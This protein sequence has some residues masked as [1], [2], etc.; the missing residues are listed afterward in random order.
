MSTEPYREGRGFPAPSPELEDFYARWNAA[1]EEL[2]RLEG[3]R[4]YRDGDLACEYVTRYDQGLH[5]TKSSLYIFPAPGDKSQNESKTHKTLRMVRK[6][7]LSMVY[8]KFRW[9]IF[10]VVLMSFVFMAVATSEE[11]RNM[12]RDKNMYYHAELAFTSF[13]CF[14]FVLKLIAMGG[15]GDEKSY[16][17]DLTNIFDFFV[18]VIGCLSLTPAIDNYGAIRS[19]RLL[20]VFKAIN[21]VRIVRR[22]VHALIAAIPALKSVA[23]FTIYIV[24]LFSAFFLRI[25]MNRL[26]YRC[27]DEAT[28]TFYPDSFCSP[29]QTSGRKCPTGQVC[30][31]YGENPQNGV[32]SFDNL[33]NSMLT[34]L[35]CIS[36]EGWTEVMFITGDAVSKWLYGIFLVLMLL[37]AMLAIKLISA[38]VVMKYNDSYQSESNIQAEIDRRKAR[39][40]RHRFYR[41]ILDFRDKVRA[42]RPPLPPHPVGNGLNADR[43]NP[44]NE[45]ALDFLFERLKQG[46]ALPLCI[47]LNLYE[48]WHEKNVLDRCA[49]RFYAQAGILER[50]V[51]FLEY[52]FR[53]PVFIGSKSPFMS[54]TKEEMAAIERERDKDIGQRIKELQTD[55][56]EFVQLLESAVLPEDYEMPVNSNPG[57]VVDIQNLD[58]Q[59]LESFYKSAEAEI[60]EEFKYYFERVRFY[61][62]LIMKTRGAEVSFFAWI[63]GVSWRDNFRRWI[64]NSPTCIM[65][66][67]GIPGQSDESYLEDKFEVYIRTFIEQGDI[68]AET[69][70]AALTRSTSTRASLFKPKE[71]IRAWTWY[72]ALLTLTSFY[73]F[74]TLC[75]NHWG[76]SS[77]TSD[78]IEASSIICLIIYGIDLIIK[79]VISWPYFRYDALNVFEFFAT[80][81][82]LIEIIWRKGA[83]SLTILQIFRILRLRSTK[84]KGIARF[85]RIIVKSASGTLVCSIVVMTFVLVCAVISRSFLSGST[86]AENEFNG[87]F[88]A[89]LRSFQIITPEN[90]NSVLYAAKEYDG[91]RGVI[92]VTFIFFVGFYIVIAM[93]TAVLISS[94]TEEDEESEERRREANL[95]ALRERLAECHKKI[96]DLRFFIPPSSFEALKTSVFRARHN[97]SRGSVTDNQWTEPF[98]KVW[99]P[100]PFETTDEEEIRQ[101]LWAWADGLNRKASRKYTRNSSTTPKSAKAALPH[102]SDKLAPVSPKQTEQTV[103]PMNNLIMGSPQ[104]HHTIQV[105]EHKHA[106]PSESDIQFE[107]DYV[108][109]LDDHVGMARSGR[110]YDPSGETNRSEFIHIPFHYLQSR[111]SVFSSFLKQIELNCS[112]LL[113]CTMCS[114]TDDTGYDVPKRNR[115]GRFVMYK[116]GSNDPPVTKTSASL[117]RTGSGRMVDSRESTVSI[118]GLEDNWVSERANVTI[119]DGH[120]DARCGGACASSNEPCSVSFVQDRMKRFLSHPRWEAV[121]LAIIIY[122]C[123]ITA[124]DHPSVDSS[125]HKGQLIFISNWTISVI[126]AVELVMKGFAFGLKT[127]LTDRWNW[128]DIVATVASFISMLLKSSRFAKGLR[129]LRAFRGV[130]FL[131]YLK[132]T[133]DVISTFLK[134]FRG[135]LTT[136]VFGL[137]L[138]TMYGV[139]GVSYF[140]GKL[141]RCYNA[142]REPLDNLNFA[143]C[144]AQGY[145]WENPVKM[146]NFDNL[147]NSL[148][149]LF[150]WSS[151][152]GWPDYMTL[153]ADATPPNM[154]PRQ[155]YH[156]TAALYV[157]AG[158]V[159]FGFFYMNLFVG[160]IVDSYANMVR[161][162]LEPVQSRFIHMYKMALDHQ[163]DMINLKPRPWRRSRNDLKLFEAP[164]NDE[165]EFIL[166]QPRPSPTN[167]SSANKL[168]DDVSLTRRT[169]VDNILSTCQRHTDQSLDDVLFRTQGWED[170]RHL[171]LMRARLYDETMAL[172]KLRKLDSRMGCFEPCGFN[173]RCSKGCNSCC[174]SYRDAFYRLRLNCFSLIDSKHFELVMLLAVVVSVVAMVVHHGE[175]SSTYKSAWDRIADICS[176]LFVIEAAAK[177]I[178]LGLNQYIRRAWRVLEFIIALCSLVDLIGNSWGAFNPEADYLNPLIFGTIRLLRMLYLIKLSRS[179]SDLFS[180]LL[181]SLSA[182]YDISFVLLIVLFIY[183]AVG[184]NLFYGVVRLEYV[185]E[186][187]NFDNFFNT[188][189]L[190]FRCA[191]GENWNGIM[192]E[193]AV[194]P[195]FCD[196]G[197]PSTCGSPSQSYVYFVSFTFIC[198]FLLLNMVVAI[199]FKNFEREFELSGDSEATASR[200]IINVM[201][202]WCRNSTPD[203]EIG[204]SKDDELRK[205]AISG[206]ASQRE[207]QILRRDSQNLRRESILRVSLLMDQTGMPISQALNASRKGSIYALME[208]LAHRSAL[209]KANDIEAFNDI[210]SSIAR[211]QRPYY[212]GFTTP[213]IPLLTVTEIPRLLWLLA[214]KHNPLFPVFTIGMLFSGKK[215]PN[216]VYLTTPLADLAVSRRQEPN[217]PLCT[218]HT[219]VTPE[220]RREAEESKEPNDEVA[221]IDDIT[222]IDALHIPVSDGRHAL[223]VD[224]LYRLI[225]HLLVRD[226]EMVSNAR[227]FLKKVLKAVDESRRNK[228]PEPAARD[229]KVKV[230]KL[231]PWFKNWVQFGQRF[232]LP[233]SK[234]K[235]GKKDKDEGDYKALMLSETCFRDLTDREAIER[236]IDMIPM[237]NVDL[238]CATDYALREMPNLALKD[239][240]ARLYT[241]GL[242]LRMIYL[243]RALRSIAEARPR[244]QSGSPLPSPTGPT[245]S[246]TPST[247][248]AATPSS[249]T[250]GPMGHGR[251]VF[252]F[253]PTLPT[254]PEDPRASMKQP[255]Q[256]R[257]S[258]PTNSEVPFLPGNAPSSPRQDYGE[259]SIPAIV[260]PEIE[261]QTVVSSRPTPRPPPGPRPSA[262]PLPSLVTDLP[263]SPSASPAP[264]PVSSVSS[265]RRLPALP[266]KQVKSPLSA[267]PTPNPSRPTTPVSHSRPP[268]PPSGKRQNE[269]AQARTL[270]AVVAD[271]MELK[272]IGSTDRTDADT[273]KSV[274][275]TSSP[276]TVGVASNEVL[277]QVPESATAEQPVDQQPSVGG[278]TSNSSIEALD[279]ANSEAPGSVHNQDDTL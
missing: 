45:L 154:E 173:R 91:W 246:G 79:L 166:G 73:N 279:C 254:T 247:T 265:T 77:T 83:T 227:D 133:R 196:V 28:D 184:M 179:L 220:E 21:E 202:S 129:A 124:L 100:H 203:N 84:L 101:R 87:F 250:S 215:R 136:F 107:G 125:S 277:V 144:I 104:P 270:A 268:T 128:W 200:G 213:L 119:E 206:E 223:Y 160:T 132:S 49:E 69:D 157:V 59:D 90:W 117:N 264:S 243:Q 275:G 272:D 205:S 30:A 74:A 168:V 78:W 255:D 2:T 120:V 47:E 271:T 116:R 131:S 273:A 31:Y 224:V 178:A 16:F 14:E 68:L 134:S 252:T 221:Y 42:Q 4:K 176:V 185:E 5:H 183:S 226:P 139:I 52:T 37:G 62:S 175:E 182:L 76:Q 92:V 80:T 140:K 65:S 194:Q 251:H 72:S 171:S 278:S 7:A 267:A 94:F 34:V 258:S 197:P 64:E 259:P 198:A 95:Q 237:D 35:V 89:V 123:V 214:M 13:F 181:F 180:T 22:H 241:A 39:Q 276:T 105:D 61:N 127:L 170:L 33:L 11:N 114:R 10:V 60:P 191:T 17:R 177:I 169:C 43:A 3:E 111:S 192:Y 106:E 86:G 93:F 25:V 46:K 112:R 15:F 66:Q 153:L 230:D 231:D 158:I 67:P 145:Y 40:A 263:A 143:D 135:C 269:Q 193:M 244:Y 63:S 138:Y 225:I 163:P 232:R 260:Q 155:D 1:F 53:D 207:S 29:S 130:R 228:A 172:R 174:F 159:T 152:E 122:S 50:I 56:L 190:L 187:S 27:K 58:G 23:V 216:K 239:E 218:F 211:N 115:R 149:V 96:D 188:F 229:N 9:A 257:D 57:L 121:I 209:L 274:L 147:G 217:E 108:K 26:K 141:H 71:W 38:M 109:E 44:E 55:L 186:H 82:A 248:P 167:S 261:L 41:R 148:L 88:W 110:P 189:V 165:G 98:R 6:L 151:M 18:L 256:S 219:I 156:T 235:E 233:S 48:A 51:S 164:T 199:V 113:E 142:D 201:L 146:G 150:E 210:W 249:A 12:G 85:S 8:G 204:H 245:P 222:I 118:M 97:A 70:D 36:M 195:P 99:V 234:S 262:R 102:S 242:A 212:R 236:A 54:F 19:L 240:H 253:S 32:I 24:F 266:F 238:R 208:S 81:I 126:Y 103:P 162:T 20:R 161:E 137:V 75:A